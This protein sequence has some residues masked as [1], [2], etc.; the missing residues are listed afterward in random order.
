MNLITHDKAY[1]LYPRATFEE[2]RSLVHHA[3]T[4]ERE[5]ALKKYEDRGWAIVKKITKEESQDRRSAFYPSLRSVGD[6]KCWTLLLNPKLDLPAGN[7]ETHTWALSY[8]R[9]LDVSMT[10]R[11]FGSRDL[12]FIYLVHPLF[13]TIV[14]DFVRQ[15]R[16]GDEYAIWMTYKNQLTDYLDSWTTYLDHY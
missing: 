13:I 1:S 14:D 7:M 10:Y 15:A 16:S 9:R 5:R 2:R 11:I 8:S 12:R 4:A 6:R 3:R